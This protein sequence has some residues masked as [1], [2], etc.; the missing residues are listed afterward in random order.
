MASTTG[1]RPGYGIRALSGKPSSPSPSAAR[2]PRAPT[3]PQKA[4]T[5]SRLNEGRTTPEVG[6]RKQNDECSQAQLY[7]MPPAL[8]DEIAQAA[9]APVDR[10]DRLEKKETQAI[11]AS[12]DSRV[13]A[14]K[15]TKATE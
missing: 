15:A 1:S 14:T 9:E 11:E 6:G 8:C 10:L 5:P 3:S 4:C 13:K 7:S 2:R 12:A